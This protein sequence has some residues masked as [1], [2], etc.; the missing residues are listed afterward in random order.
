VSGLSTASGAAPKAAR[1]NRSVGR[2]AALSPAQIN[3]NVNRL[4]SQMTVEQK[5]GQLEMAGPSSPTGSDLVPLAQSGQIGTV[6]DLT[7]VDNIN[8]VQKAAVEST[9]KG[10][11]Q[12]P[13]EVRG[14]PVRGIS[15]SSTA[16][17]ELRRVRRRG[18][19]APA[20]SGLSA[21]N[22][23]ATEDTVSPQASAI[24]L[25]V[26]P[27]E[28]CANL[29]ALRAHFPGIYASDGGFYDAVNPVTGAVGHRR[30]VLDQ[31]MITA[32]LDDVLD[33][34]ALQRHFAADPESWPARL[35]LSIERMSIQ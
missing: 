25:R 22:G 29:G 4:I 8:A 35:Y 13:T 18:P 14:H 20:A 10:S 30:L 2:T 5:L 34:G 9:Q 33:D 19:R 12:V 26:L 11:D 31:S 1:A 7:G 23:C 17:R 16:H 24:A 28:V 32:A 6:L 27:D 21:C 3:A 15:P